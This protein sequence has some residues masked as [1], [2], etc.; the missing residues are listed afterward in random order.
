MRKVTPAQTA[1]PLA[2]AA[3]LD[4]PEP[5]KAPSN[6]R[7]A[8]G[9]APRASKKKRTN[10]PTVQEA[11]DDTESDNNSNVA[12]EPKKAASKKRVSKKRA[13][14]K[15]AS[16]KRTAQEAVEEIDSDN[17]LN[18]P[19]QQDPDEDGDA[20]YQDP[21]E[22]ALQAGGAFEA[23]DEEPEPKQKT[24]SQQAKKVAGSR[25][26]GIRLEVSPSAFQ[27]INAGQRQ[28]SIVDNLT[29]QQ[30][31][32]CLFVFKE[33]MMHACTSR[34]DT[35]KSDEQQ[36]PSFCMSIRMRQYLRSTTA[37]ALYNI[38]NAI[39]RRRRIILG[40]MFPTENLTS[41]TDFPGTTAGEL[42]SWLYA[43]LVSLMNELFMYGGSAT[44]K[45]E[46]HY[47]FDRPSG[48]EKLKRRADRGEDVSDAMAKSYHLPKGLALGARMDFRVLATFDPTSTKTRRVIVLAVEGIII[49]FLQAAP[50][51][52]GHNADM[53]RLS[54]EAGTG[55]HL[56]WMN[57]NFPWAGLNHAS[58]FRQGVQADSCIRRWLEAHGLTC[59]M[60]Q[61]EKRPHGQGKDRWHQTITSMRKHA[62]AAE[63]FCR[64]CYNF[65]YKRM[66]GDEIIGGRETWTPDDVVKVRRAPE[67]NKNFEKITGTSAD[68]AMDV[69]QQ[70]NF[71]CPVC[72]RHEHSTLWKPDT[73]AKNPMS[74]VAGM[75]KADVGCPCIN[76][77]EQYS[78]YCAGP[79]NETDWV[80]NRQSYLEDLD[81]VCRLFGGKGTNRWNS[82]K[83]LRAHAKNF[84]LISARMSVLKATGGNCP[85]CTKH[86]WDEASRTVPVTKAALRKFFEEAGK[87]Q[88][89]V[90]QFVLQRRTTQQKQKKNKK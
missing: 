6:K 16:K 27:V 23:E 21:E 15:R 40:G 8:S 46:L 22:E 42:T 58:P 18:I 88:N 78:H 76:C 47:G 63:C 51:K 25:R 7:A 77:N 52:F 29:T 67:S 83:S 73:W 75:S 17:D 71:T 33:R 50:R 36:S 59:W 84:H 85:C 81:E 5:N 26:P 31:L 86:M 62:D 64:N 34:I 61:E 1:S 12:P 48:Y 4:D 10:K 57:D 41:F 14:K 20:D 80:T 82:D 53:L 74:T 56:P 32:R 43:D 2:T 69:L 38:K 37:E 45:R 39:T 87:T 9:Q 70:Q 35:A 79:A 72:A 90:D 60:C 49:E 11:L 28:T 55:G 13:S 54:V 30:Q 3:F 65:A 19:S 66:H 44:A 89:D 68:A 24:K